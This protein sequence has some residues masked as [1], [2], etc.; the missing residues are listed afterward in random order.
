MVMRHY[1]PKKITVRASQ[2]D[3]TAQSAARIIDQIIDLSQNNTR[4]QRFLDNH[5]L[6]KIT[7]DDLRSDKHTF[8][9]NTLEGKVAPRVGDYIV[10]G[11]HGEIYP[12]L[13]KIFEEKYEF[14]E[15]E[16]MRDSDMWPESQR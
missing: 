13:R 1:R 12:V 10:I 16:N 7:R 2:Y 3:G 14:V 15:W 8:E 4:L 9:V 5:G 11:T 6:P